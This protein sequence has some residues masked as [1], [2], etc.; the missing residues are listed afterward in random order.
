MCGIFGVINDQNK[1]ID[2]DLFKISAKLMNHRG[3]DSYGQWGIDN[4]IELGHLRLSIIDLKAESNQPFFS[5]CEQYVIIYN[6]E[7]YNYIELRDELINIGY[8]FRTESDTEVLLN[9][10]IEWGEKCVTK[11]NG[12]WAFA[13]YDLENEKLFCSRDRFGVKPFNYAFVDG[14]LIFSSEIKSILSYYNSLKKP[15]YNVIANFC[16]TSVGAQHEETWFKDIFRLKPAHNLIFHKGEIRKYRYWSYP[17]QTNNK[18]NFE[19]AKNIYKELFIDA[20]KIRMR[21]DVPVGT[22]LSSGVD[23]NSILFTLR[24]FHKEKLH[25]FTACFDSTNF[26]FRDKEIYVSKDIEIDESIIVRKYTKDLGL[27]NHFIDSSYDSFVSDLNRII[28]LLESGHSSTAIVPLMQVL[29]CAH[30]YVT[31]VLEGQGADELLGYQQKHFFS[32]LIVSLKKLRFKTAFNLY[33]KTTKEYSLSY[34]FLMYLRYLS[35]SFTFLNRI[36]EYRSGISKVFSKKL[37]VNE[38]MSDAPVDKTLKFDCRINE[39]LYRQ[40]VGG[41]GNLLHYGDTI[42]MANSLESRLPFMDFRLVEFSF[43]LPWNF[44]IH[45]NITK[46]IHREAMKGILPEEILNSTL[47]FGFN[48]PTSQFFKKDNK[49]N[50]K[51]LDIILSERCLERN[52]FNKEALVSIINAHD[53]DKSNHSTFLYRIL[54]VELWFREFIDEK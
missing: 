17:T 49:L 51:P 31:V 5:S 36:Y 28:Y 11:F 25:T 39:E 41:L 47:K 4:H 52:L 18:I 2:R 21:S 27:T 24:E 13:I 22:T 16:R 50:I 26:S 40:H 46:Y 45:E 23:S 29:E 44:K 3:P 34:A 43:S 53:S 35:N 12:D 1:E 20:V 54:C 8:T 9:S 33:K 19:E 38:R 32:T 15:N 48:T 42:S 14:C 37:K 30:D 6:G 10:Y 7:I